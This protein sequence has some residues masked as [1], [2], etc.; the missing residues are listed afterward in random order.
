MSNQGYI[1]DSHNSVQ[2]YTKSFDSKDHNIY[3]V[4]DSEAQNDSSN[5]VKVTVYYDA[6]AK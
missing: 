4:S 1:T 3:Y 2:P 5:E 6:R